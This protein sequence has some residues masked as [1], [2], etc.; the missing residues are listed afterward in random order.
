V[1][2]ASLRA[3]AAVDSAKVGELAV[4]EEVLALELLGATAHQGVRARLAEARGWASLAARDGTVLLAPLGAELARPRRCRALER[5]S[6]RQGVALTSAKVG[7]LQVSRPAGL[8]PCPWDP[9]G[10]CGGCF[11]CAVYTAWT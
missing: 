1:G 10:S 5:V 2:R 7:E 9:R 3:G 6:I 8:M 11:L 4:G